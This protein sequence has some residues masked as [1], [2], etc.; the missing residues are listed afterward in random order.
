MISCRDGYGL[1]Y[2]QPYAFGYEIKDPHHGSQWRKENSD[3]H[4]VEGSYGY[5]DAWGIKRQ[6]DYIADKHGFRAKV[7]TNEPGTANEHP[8]HVKMNSH[9]ALLL[10]ILCAID[11]LSTRIKDLKLFG[12]PY[13]WSQKP[14]HLYEYGY[15][16]VDKHGNKHWKK[17]EKNKKGVVIGSYGYINVNG[18]KRFV[19]YV[20]DHKGFRV[21]INSNEPG[22]AIQHPAHV[23]IYTEPLFV[24]AGIISVGL[25]EIGHHI[26]HYYPQ[27][28]AFGYEIKDPHHGSQWRKENSDGHKVEGSYG[29]VD[30]W[31]IKR[32]VDYIADKHGF[33]AKVKTNEPGT[34]NE[35]PAHVK[36]NSHAYQPHG[37]SFLF[38]GHHH[39]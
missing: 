34:A 2:P 32:Q 7:K 23:H 16:I 35:H 10:F 31:G 21:K 15:D 29:Y 17:E 26:H 1:Y 13:G 12:M 36:M 33:R 6:V 9:F 22:T 37:H 5:V 38:K 8:A 18:I 20:A 14:I 19:N 39:Y 25:A 27:P 30:A 24:L 11:T 4:K 3:G 28:Y